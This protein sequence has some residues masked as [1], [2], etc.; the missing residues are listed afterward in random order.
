MLHPLFGITSLL[1]EAKCFLVEAFCPT[2]D[3]TERW[4]R[5]AEGW[6]HKRGDEEN[7]DSKELAQLLQAAFGVTF[8]KVRVYVGRQV[9]IFS[10]DNGNVSIQR[11]AS[12]RSTV[13]QQGKESW[14]ALSQALG[15]PHSKRKAKLEQAERFAQLVL[16]NVSAEAEGQKLRILDLACGRSYLG[17]V[18]L[19]HLKS[20]RWGGSLHGIDTNPDL[21]ARCETIRDKL[22]WLDCTFE[23]AD[24][25]SYSAHVGQYDIMVSLHACD[26]LSDDAIT[27]AWR[28]QVPWLF[29]APCCQQEL[30]TLWRTHPL[31]WMSRY[32]T[33]EENLASSITDGL[34]CLVLDALGYSVRVIPFVSTKNTPKNLMI[35]AKLVARPDP[36]RIKEVRTF[37][38]EFGVQPKI[39]REYF[40]ALAE[41]SGSP[42]AR[43]DKSSLGHKH[44]RRLSEKY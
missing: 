14:E 29:I 17:F 9:V 25:T 34:R 41:V 32:P 6:T 24:L 33:L 15:I 8:Q 1:A 7:C 16:E 28:S 20:E 30:R 21:V 37:V 13:S 43:R 2:T 39:V 4:Q 3:C 40:G 26:T 35:K 23:A 18:L 31:S 10:L 38:E 22:G 5:V 19:H 12:E 11:Q 36:E 27:V 42:D 44:L